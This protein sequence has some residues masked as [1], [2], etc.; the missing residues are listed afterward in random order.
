MLLLGGFPFSFVLLV[1][2]VRCSFII[3][4]LPNCCSFWIIHPLQSRFPR[5]A[6]PGDLPSSIVVR[7]CAEMGH[8][9][10]LWKVAGQLCRCERVEFVCSKAW[11]LPGI[12]VVKIASVGT[13]TFLVSYLAIVILGNRSIYGTCNA[14]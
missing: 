7:S 6:D 1:A 4:P 2:A 8:R 5:F 14:P 12:I 10:N 3:R 9:R 11:K 13:S